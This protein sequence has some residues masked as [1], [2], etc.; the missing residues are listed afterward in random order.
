MPNIANAEWN[1]NLKEGQGHFDTGALDGEYSFKSRFE[2]EKRRR[3][4]PRAA[5]R[6][7]RTPP[8]SRWS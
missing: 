5:D 4:E 3:R 8:A 6:A 1:G 7:P 2:D